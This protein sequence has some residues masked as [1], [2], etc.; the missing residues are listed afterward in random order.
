M[1]QV[2][3]C[4]VKTDRQKK[5]DEKKE[6][7]NRLIKQEEEG[8]IIFS[9]QNVFA[10]KLNT[11]GYGI[12]YEVGKQK[13]IKKANI[14]QFELGE[15]KH[16]KEERIA[17]TQGLFLINPFVY[18]K[19]NNFYYFKAGYLQQQLI[20]GKGNKNGVAVSALYGGGIT[21]GLLKPYY[22]K[23]EDPQTGIIS[24]VKYNNNDSIFLD[25][26][27]IR[28][29]SGFTMGFGEI[30]V[31][32]GAFV[33]A[34]LRFDYGRFNEVVSALEVGINVEVYASKI[35][36]MLQNKEK[37]LFFNAYAAIAFGKRK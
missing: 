14:F 7:I 37:Q 24:D 36:H 30:K 19:I 32:P 33:K 23:V 9:R 10:I 15:R 26:I 21:L 4:Q 11:D 16:A 20:G 6:R 27:A 28:G 34:A 3:D 29:S 8:A 17:P 12:M 22:L 35:P 13:S 2:G 18:G 25:P 31:K 1:Y 5:N